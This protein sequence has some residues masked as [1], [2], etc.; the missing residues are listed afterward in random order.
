MPKPDKTKKKPPGKPER[1]GKVMD[2][3]YAGF[4]AGENVDDVDAAWAEYSEDGR[5]D[6]SNGELADEPEDDVPEE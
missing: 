2:A 3:F 5:S 4:D 6:F 1:T